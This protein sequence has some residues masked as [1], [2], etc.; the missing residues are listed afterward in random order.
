MTYYEQLK[1]P[2]WQ[3]KRLE[4]FTRDNFTCISCGSFHET[5]HVHHGV[6]IKGLKAWQY[7]SKHLHTLCYSCHDTTELFIPTIYQ[8]I[9]ETNPSLLWDIEWIFK[10]IKS[11]GAESLR[12][13]IVETEN[14]K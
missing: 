1:D 11:G 7:E 4:I 13:W 12:K 6:Y 9:G 8:L 14:K 2:R 3:K 5:L 10:W